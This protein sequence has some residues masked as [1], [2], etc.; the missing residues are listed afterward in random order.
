MT[1]FSNREIA[2][3][4]WI[5]AAMLL[6]LSKSELRQGMLN[7]LKAFF[8]PKILLSIVFMLV[9]TVAIVIVLWSIRLW[10]HALLKDTALWFCLTG[11]VLVFDFVTSKSNENVFWRIV[12][13]NARVVVLIE[14]LVNAYTFSLVVELLLVPVV[15]FIALIEAVAGTNKEHAVVAKIARRILIAFGLAVISY[16]VVKAI[17]DFQNLRN[18]E[19]ARSFVLAPLLS[20][21]FSPFLYFTLL[22][23]NY[24]LL[25]VRLKLGPEKDEDL[26]RYA[27]RRIIRHCRFSLGKVRALLKAGAVDL[28][29]LQ[30]K[31][32]VCRMLRGSAGE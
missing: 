20:L 2:T 31:D 25:F 26:Q 12:V 27:K 30:R 7:V 32:D 4:L 28:I 24:E 22:I 1:L 10:N 8:Q 19:T 11:V 5:L 15:T 14:F 3:G 16:V 21:L 17:S 9:Y 18:L 23:T 13:D 29:R 6:A